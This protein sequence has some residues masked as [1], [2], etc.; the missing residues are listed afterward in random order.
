MA[1]A[2]VTFLDTHGMP[3][4]EEAERSIGNGTVQAFATRAPIHGLGQH[5]NGLLDYSGS[6]DSPAAEERRHRGA[7]AAEPERLRH[8]LEQRV[9]HGC[10]R[11]QGRSEIPAGDP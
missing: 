11:R 10:R 6:S 8:P 1:T 7:D 4:L 3:V 2:A 5:Q 9:V